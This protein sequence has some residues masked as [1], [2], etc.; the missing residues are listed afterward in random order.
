VAHLIELYGAQDLVD[1]YLPKILSGQ[2]QGTMAMTE[3]EA[4]S[5][6]SDIA[7]SAEPTDNGYYKIQGQKIFISAGDHDAVENI[8]HLM[9]GRIKGAPPGVKGLS[10]FVVPQKRID[11]DG[12]LVFNDVVTSGVFHKL[13]YRG[14]PLTQLSIGDKDDCRGYLIGEP[15]KGLSYMFQMMNEER[16]GVGIGA[17]GGQQAPTMLLSIIPRNA[18][19]EENPLRKIPLNRRSQLLS[20]QTSRECCSFNA[21]WPKDPYPCCYSAVNT[22]TFKP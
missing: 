2:W 21:R 14:C 10:L 22:W 17:T 8:V 11:E 15:H 5:S 3:P 16:I 13:G 18:N 6:L 20:M 4:G 1:R 12:S 19:R 9:L 7:T